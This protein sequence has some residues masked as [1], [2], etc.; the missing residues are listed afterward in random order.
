V[1]TDLLGRIDPTTLVWH[2]L[3]RHA[4]TSPDREAVIHLSSE[5]DPVRWTWGPLLRAASG[6]AA[7]LAIHGVRKG[8]VCALIVRHH[9]SFYPL[10]LGVSALGALPSVLAY[11]NARLHPDKFRQGLEGMSR[12]SG[13]DHILTERDLEPLVAPLVA[14]HG[15]TIKQVLFP[16]EAENV[17]ASAGST[18]AD[19]APGHSD[20]PCLLQHS[21]GTTGLQ[22]PVALSHR[23]V[24]EHVRR[25][26]EAIGLNQHDRIVS[27]LP[28]Y[29]DMGLIAAFYLPMVAGIPLIQLSPMEW[30]AAP[31]LLLEAISQERGTL[32]WLPNFSYRFMADRIRDE[33]IPGCRLDSLRLIVNCS[34]PV[35]S[36]SHD[37]FHERFAPHGLRK[38]ALGA[39]YAMAETTYAATQTPPGQEARRVLV[40]RT[41]M[42]QGRVRILREVETTAGRWCVSSGPA[43]SGCS[44]R[45]VDE[46]RKDLPDGHVGEI[47]I[48]SVSLFDGYRNYPEKTAEVLDAGWYFSGDYGFVHEGAWYVVGRKK[49]LVIVAGNNVFPE[50]VE[51]VV[52]SVPGVLPGR[53]VAFAADDERMGT[54]VLCVIAET[55]ARGAC[56]QKALR[57]AILQAGMSIDV[58]ISRAYLAPPRW[59]IKSSSGKPARSTNRDRALAELQW[60]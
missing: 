40:D 4:D 59:L 35:R 23:A 25:Y 52:G 20:E 49:D 36:E 30:V 37:R 48:T 33:D 3:V 42:A 5:H 34:E 45:V 16:L 14:G 18:I 17:E 32:C 29:H 51:D 57:L 53:V 19:H 1:T 46:N 58:T 8:D 60:K 2:H 10:Y 6:Y 56:D 41:A 44:L 7:W 39:S 22:K 28:L 38:E 55:E 9:P 27:W 13:L 24:L 12:R 21:S 54:D 50:D 15:S 43:I 26:G 11:P 47:A 31:S